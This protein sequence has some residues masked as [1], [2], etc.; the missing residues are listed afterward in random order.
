MDTNSCTPLHLAATYS[1]LE[2]A[3]RLLNEGANPRAR[4]CDRRTPLLEACSAGNFDIVKVLFDHSQKL[5]GLD[6][7]KKVRLI[8]KMHAS[9]H[10]II[11]SR[12]NMPYHEIH[13]GF[14]IWSYR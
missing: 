12:L 3:K 1:S 7:V 4:D 11:Q 5:F 6:Y 9:E 8:F 14:I 13:Y 10:T 2:V